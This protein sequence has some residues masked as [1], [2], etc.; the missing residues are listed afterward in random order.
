[1]RN[2]ND[3]IRLAGERAVE[4]GHA[5]AGTLPVYDGVADEAAYFAQ[6]LRVA[7]ILKEPW[8]DFDE[9]GNPCGGGW[10]LVKD[11]FYK[12]DAW[13]NPVWQKIAY[14]MHGFRAGQVWEQMPWIRDARE[15][16]H[17]I[18]SI[19]WLNVNKM[20]S[21]TNSSDGRF[22]RL[23]NEVWR[24]VLRRQIEV[25]DPQVMIF[26]RTF[27]CFCN[28]EYK[29][30]VFYE[31]FSNRWVKFYRYGD[32]VLLDTYHP[33]RKG[34]A[35]VNALIEALKNAKNELELEG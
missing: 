19:A 15:M 21:L 33:G 31:R 9:K 10:S 3:S 35:Y 12:D 11:A 13:K 7:W 23:Y 2:I 14:V 25:L 1:M 16:I 17:E 30:A 24:D 34:G 22:V 26:A 27:G 18:R 28:S 5:K 4:L 20:P 32:K 8:D 29:D 6:K